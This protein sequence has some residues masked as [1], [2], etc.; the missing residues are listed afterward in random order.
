MFSKKKNIFRAI[1]VLIVIFFYLCLDILLSRS[2]LSKNEN[3]YYFEKYYYELKKE[4]AGKDQFKSSFPTVNIYTDEL[5]LRSKKN[6]SKNSNKSNVFVFGDSFTYGVGLEYEETYVGILERELPKY[7]FYNF[8]VGSYSPTVHYYRLQKAIKNKIIPKKII[9]FLDLTDVYDEGARWNVKDI[10]EKPF[11]ND[12]S[13][14][15]ANK[16]KENFKEKNFKITKLLS[17]SVNFNLRMLKSKIKNILKEKNGSTDVK[18]SFQ[19]QFTYTK[20]SNLNS[21]YWSKEIFEKGIKKI[22]K[23]ITYIDNIANK[24]SSDFYL[25]VYPWA[26]TLEYGQNKFDWENF[27]Q[28]LCIKGNCEVINTIPDF[29]KFKNDN[30]D[31]ST[32]LYFP[33]DEHFYKRGNMLVANIVK[34]YITK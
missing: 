18:T 28:S 32:Q 15:Q 22:A 20:V 27:A 21:E 14:Y 7:N 13:I 25:V 5:G 24:Y 33:K 29:I 4:C 34:K 6:Y 16:V 2:I 8:A 26:E 30:P 3:C 12:D 31:W 17:S 23:N 1:S 9:L 11:L 19:G 10:S